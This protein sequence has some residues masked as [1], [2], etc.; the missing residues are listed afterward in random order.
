VTR[1]LQF[2]RCVHLAE[3]WP[4]NFLVAPRRGRPVVIT[5]KDRAPAVATA[6]EPA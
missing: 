4:G 1:R 2:N 5:L 3:Q 6:V